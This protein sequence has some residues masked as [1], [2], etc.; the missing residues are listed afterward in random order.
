M[1]YLSRRFVAAVVCLLTLLV[2]P[3]GPAAAQSSPA[4][5]EAAQRRANEA[6]RRYSEA[7]SRLARTQAE[8]ARLQQQLTETE[9]QLSELQGRVRDFAVRQYVNG[10]TID[11]V[12]IDNEDLTAAA[13]AQTMAEFVFLGSVQTID[14]YRTQRADLQSLR[15]ALAQKREE[16]QRA[17]AELRSR[18]QA[19][20]A[21]VARLGALERQRLSRERAR[22][23]AEAA[24][25]RS[26]S[27][28]ATGVIATGPWVCPVQG[29]HAFSNDWGQPR[30]GGRRHQGNDIFAPYGTPTVA[31]VSGT[32]THRS[33]SR[34]GLS[35]YV[36]GDDGNV[37]FG[38][39]LSAYAAGGRVAGGTV[40]GYVGT[41][42]NARGSSP[43]LHFEIHPGGGAAVN[44]YFTLRKYC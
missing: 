1:S 12:L 32:V 16:E 8:I 43:H 23:A 24:A 28:G 44:P 6:A 33:V 13:R 9:G 22:R 36:R 29:P 39:H 30:S 11:T 17:A 26:R 20:D 14:E 40:I 15:E 38:T 4:K 31:P 18:R 35:W 27:S 41:S 10:S 42:G 2:A 34:G 37:Y 25:R 21:E 3:A 7:Q 5:L 19:A